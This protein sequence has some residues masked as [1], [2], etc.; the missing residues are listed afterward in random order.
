V[1]A[2]PFPHFYQSCAAATTYQ[3]RSCL[4]RARGDNRADSDLDLAVV[5]NGERG[6]FI[7]T[8][9]DMAGL[10]FGVL[11]ETGVLVQAFPMWE[12]DLDHPE[13]FPNP[14]ACSFEQPGK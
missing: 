11:M 1:T 6:N 5:L 4:D 9:L 13:Q 8:K 14:A 2:A 10:A 3:R 7:D 12:D